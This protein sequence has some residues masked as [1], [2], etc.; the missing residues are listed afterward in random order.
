MLNFKIRYLALGGVG[1]VTKNMHVY[2]LYQND[3]LK[4]ILIVD[5]GIGFPGR[6]RT[7]D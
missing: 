1:D 3:K 6:K 4:D 5:C 7:G 2:E